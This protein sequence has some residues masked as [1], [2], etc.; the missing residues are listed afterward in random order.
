[1][2]SK[3]QPKPGTSDAPGGLNPLHVVVLDILR[4]EF[5]TL[6]EY[7]STFFLYPLLLGVLC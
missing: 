4:E 1:M 2:T 7:L 6:K 5:L 3:S